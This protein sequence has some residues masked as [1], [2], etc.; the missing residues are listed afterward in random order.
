MYNFPNFDE[1]SN[2]I[3]F[4]EF[5][6]VLDYILKP[7]K[8]SVS[9]YANVLKQ[10][11]GPENSAE[12]IAKQ[13]FWE[14]LSLEKF[15]KCFQILM[16]QYID[17]WELEIQGIID[18]NTNIVKKKAYIG[19]IYLFDSINLKKIFK[20]DENLPYGFDFEGYNNKLTYADEKELL[21]KLKSI[22]V[23]LVRN[24]A[25][26]NFNFDYIKYYFKKKINF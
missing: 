7:I 18:N 8:I 10:Y 11:K 1:F 14:N 9:H 26:L 24:K 4:K 20:F 6:E 22:Q 23:N 21:E 13:M 15:N 25:N 17:D 12:F 16:N 3:Y 5:L 19:F 2:S